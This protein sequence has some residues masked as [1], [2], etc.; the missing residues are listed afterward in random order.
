MR[1]PLGWATE[2][3]L[4]GQQGHIETVEPSE[5]PNVVMITGGFPCVNASLCGK[6]EGFGDKTVGRLVFD[7][8]Y[9]VYLSSS[10]FVRLTS[11]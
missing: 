10:L 2:D 5:I 1:A 4:L 7:L 6:L 9:Q 11:P 8:I 3:K